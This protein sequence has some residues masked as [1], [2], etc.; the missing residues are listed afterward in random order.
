MKHKSILIIFL[1]CLQSVISN[2]QTYSI[3]IKGG[4]VIDP[5]NNINQVMDV[6]IFEGKIKK[7][8]KDIDP[9][10]ARQVVDAKGMYVTPGLIDIHEG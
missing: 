9:K 2:A 3:L 7:V 5:K 10:E 8:A 6:G 4:T 1:V